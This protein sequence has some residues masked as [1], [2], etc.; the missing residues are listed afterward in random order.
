MY[1]IVTGISQIQRNGLGLISAFAVTH[2]IL[3]RLQ[4]FKSNHYRVFVEMFAQFIIKFRWASF[5]EYFW[6]S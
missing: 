6:V 4:V 3:W 5:I 2:S 1:L